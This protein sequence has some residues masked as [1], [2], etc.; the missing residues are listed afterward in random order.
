MRLRTRRTMRHW[1][2]AICIALSASLLAAGLGIAASDDAR[3]QAKALILDGFEQGEATA[4]CPDGHRAVGGG[5]VQSGRPWGTVHA[6]APLDASGSA[7]KTRSGDVARE[8][9]ASVSHGENSNGPHVYKVMAVCSADS[10]ARLK[11][12]DFEVRSGE[13]GE[14]FAACEPGKRVLGGG[15]MQL[16]DADAALVAASG[17]LDE[18]GTTLETNN[19]DIPR[20]WYAAVTNK[21]ALSLPFRVFAI[22]ASDTRARIEAEQLNVDPIENAEA[23]VSCKPGQRA[24]GGG[25]VQSGPAS[26]LSVR[27]SGPLDAS[28]ITM[29]TRTGD[30][31]RHWYSVMENRHYEDDRTV[32]LFAICA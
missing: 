8:W 6:S 4:R 21:T 20:Q 9:H 30:V 15:V 26:A 1:A 12:S 32:R 19:G 11:V 29:E 23:L 7:F 25:V 17:P 2:S 14:A 22:C 27:A 31:A 10:T 13:T 5:V 3:I 24:L 28:G 16:V 18:T